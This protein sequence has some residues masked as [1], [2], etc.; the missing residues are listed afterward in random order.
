MSGTREYKTVSSI[1][2]SDGRVL[3][4][5]ERNGRQQAILE[6]EATGNPGDFT[7]RVHEGQA[8]KLR[9]KFLNNEKQTKVGDELP[10]VV[11]PPLPSTLEGRDEALGV[12]EEV[13]PEEIPNFDT[14]PA[15]SPVS[16]SV[17]VTGDGQTVK[18]TSDLV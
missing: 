7:I 3:V 4:F 8:R 12:N 14:F 13:K 1:K 6:S 2:T 17:S 15:S 9:Q 16:S 5:V 18:S 10:P 11:N